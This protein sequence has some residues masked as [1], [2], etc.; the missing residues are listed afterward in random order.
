[1]NARHWV[2]VDEQ[3]RVLCG[4][5][6]LAMSDCSTPYSGRRS[7]QVFLSATQYDCSLSHVHK[8]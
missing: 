2:E 7:T 4:A 8:E 3:A 1:M 6:M 5:S